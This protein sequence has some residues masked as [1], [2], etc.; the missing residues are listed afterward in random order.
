MLIMPFFNWFSLVFI[1]VR[2]LG[3]KHI[4]R[5]A[6]LDTLFFVLNKRKLLTETIESPYWNFALFLLRLCNVL[7]RTLQS[8]SK[9]FYFLLH[10]HIKQPPPALLSND[11]AKVHRLSKT[12]KAIPTAKHKNLNCGEKHKLCAWKRV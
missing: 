10:W 5:Y 9:D 6:K 3:D 11:T 7:T 8:S 12:I 4:I 1:F 2:P